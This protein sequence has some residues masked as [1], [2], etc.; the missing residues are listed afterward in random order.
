MFTAE[1]VDMAH[2]EALRFL[3]RI[4][5]CKK[6]LGGDYESTRKR[7]AAYRSAMDLRDALVELCKRD[8][9]TNYV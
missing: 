1:T 5:A 2:K 9:G 6:H 4:E 7:L 8:A 3:V